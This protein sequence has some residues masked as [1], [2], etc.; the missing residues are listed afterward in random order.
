MTDAELNYMVKQLRRVIDPRA[1][2]SA[3]YKDE[4][5]GYVVTAPDVNWAIKRARGPF[6]WMRMVQLPLLLKKIR[7]C[8]L[9]AIGV[10]P[11]FRRKGIMSVL[12]RRMFDL[13]AKD[14]RHWEFGWIAEDNLASIGALASSV[15]LDRYRTYHVYQKAL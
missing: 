5:V 7:Q 11:D 14:Y 15:A 9:I 3:Y 13:A 2:V 1:V 4:L 10:H 6:D 12:T 8:R